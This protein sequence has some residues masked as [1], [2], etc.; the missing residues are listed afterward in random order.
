MATGLQLS[1]ANVLDEAV[2]NGLQSFVLP[3][4]GL[5]T[6]VHIRDSVIIYKHKHNNVNLERGAKHE[7][8]G[9]DKGMGDIQNFGG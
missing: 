4:I 3:K 5:Q 7:S 9:Y 1:H 8:T 6:Y 2:K